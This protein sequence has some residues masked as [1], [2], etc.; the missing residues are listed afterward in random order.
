MKEKLEKLNLEI[1]RSEAKLKE[2]KK[3]YLAL[4]SSNVSEQNDFGTGI[5]EENCYNQ[6]LIEKDNLIQQTQEFSEVGSWNYNFLE[7]KLT[8]SDEVYKMFNYPENFKGSLLDFYKSCLDELTVNRLQEI[9]KSIK[10]IANMNHAIITPIGEKKLLSYT[11]RPILNEEGEVI[12]AEGLVKDISGDITGSN[13]LNNFF[14]LSFDL[15][16][17]VHWDAYFVKVSPSWTK[18]LGYSEKELFAQSFLEFV[19][20]DDMDHTVE[21]MKEIETTGSTATFENRYITKSGKVVHLSWNTH[22][23]KE[24]QLA[25]CTARDVTKSKLAQHELLND[26]SEKDLL[27]KEIHHR[28]K[29]NLQIISSLLSLQSGANKGETKLAKLYQES[30]NRIQSM[31]SIHEMFYH[32]DELDKI[33][34]GKYLDKL[35]GDLTSTFSSNSIRIDFSMQLTPIQ[36]SLDTAIPLG[37]LMNEVITNSIKHGGDSNGLVKILIEIEDLSDGKFQ[38]TMGDEGV[39][40][41]RNI[42]TNSCE[43]L[44]VL[45][46]NSLVEQIDGEI[47]QLTDLSG[48]VFRL[49]FENKLKR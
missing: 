12:A 36:V 33:E 27:L 14:N 20:P 13:G 1:A 38:F 37:L 29:N 24:T 7:N 30:K 16:C 42:L 8:W 3:Q 28:V 40:S 49:T 47:V 44:G 19:H 46:I 35:V 39:N 25:Y 31:A 22:L 10:S 15:H 11:S 6:I 41:P 9:K 17:I 2:L 18:I 23:D 5:S 48:V 45:L 26:L 43:S 34:F 21:V 32:S 4:N